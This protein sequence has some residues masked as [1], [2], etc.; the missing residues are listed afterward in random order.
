MLKFARNLR[1]KDLEIFMIYK[2]S[3]S[4]GYLVIED[5]R[6]PLTLEDIQTTFVYMVED[7][8]ENYKNIIKVDIVS[9]ESLLS[10]DKELI[11]FFSDGLVDTKDY[12]A[13]LY[14]YKVDSSLFEELKLP[15]DVSFY[16]KLLLSIGSSYD[17][18]NLHLD[19]LMYLS[20]D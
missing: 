17:V 9:D 15:E 14:S 8:L 10:E 5:L 12:C 7:D 2:E 4:L 19:N 11:E 20:Q 6:R 18:S 16:Q 13:T 3:I 1:L